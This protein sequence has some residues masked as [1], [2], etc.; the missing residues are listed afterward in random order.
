MTVG[1]CFIT[2]LN[3]QTFLKS[4]LSGNY[5]WNQSVQCST[6]RAFCKKVP[7]ECVNGLCVCLHMYVYI[8]SMCVYNWVIPP[9]NYP[10]GRYW[11]PLLADTEECRGARKHMR[12]HV[13]LCARVVNSE[14][15]FAI[16]KWLTS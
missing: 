9:Y 1:S 16:L 15:L 4:L 6:V 12:V 5:W 7:G 14:N 11:C 10:Y 8:K 3:L 13:K 2:S